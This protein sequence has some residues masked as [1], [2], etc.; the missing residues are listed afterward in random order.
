MKFKNK[1]RGQNRAEIKK[2]GQR[3]QQ[4]FK[5]QRKTLQVRGVITSR[6]L[7]LVRCQWALIFPQ[8]V[9]PGTARAIDLHQKRQLCSAKQPHRP[10]SC[11]LSAWKLV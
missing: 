7:A 2:K 11:Q 10:D 6:L 8:K 9:L 5:G 3:E 4:T 1:K